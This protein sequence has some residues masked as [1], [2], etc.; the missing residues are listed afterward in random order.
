MLLTVGAQ[1]IQQN[2]I[3]VGLFICLYNKIFNK[4][5][6]FA[7]RAHT[8]LIGF[9]ARAILRHV[10]VYLSAQFKTLM[11]YVSARYL[12]HKKKKTKSC[13]KQIAASLLSTQTHTRF[14]DTQIMQDL[15]KL[16]L[17]RHR[18]AYYKHKT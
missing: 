6:I 3:I 4:I 18:S 1:F 7:V 13:L 5:L 10:H 9:S 17:C 8:K 11:N 14:R 16:Y 12:F 15:I 2:Y